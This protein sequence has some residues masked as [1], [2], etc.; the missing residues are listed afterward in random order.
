M[1]L[2]AD[3]MN[4][5][6]NPETRTLALVPADKRTKKSRCRETTMERGSILS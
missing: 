6:F 1:I 3:A 4:F 2:Y 5:T